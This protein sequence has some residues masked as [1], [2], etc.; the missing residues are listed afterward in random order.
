[1]TTSQGELTADSL[2]CILQ[3]H[4]TAIMS[5]IALQQARFSD[6]VDA[7][8]DA[9]VSERIA[10][11][12]MDEESF[13]ASMIKAVAASTQTAFATMSADLSERVTSTVKA[14]VSALDVKFRALLDSSSSV[15]SGS[16]ALSLSSQQSAR[17]T[18]DS[19]NSRQVWRCP[20]CQFPLKHEKSFH[21]HL[22]L[23]QSRVHEMPVVYG[24]RRS[25]KVKKCLFNIERPELHLLL[26]PWADSHPTFWSQAHEFVRHLLC[27]LKPGTEQAIQ[28]DNPRHEIVF[29]WIDNCRNG[30]FK[31]NP[32]F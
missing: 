8:I 20:V 6:E 15:H 7:K 26:Q 17:S 27:M 10:V 5:Q 30:V 21:D 25:Q 24:R 18:S 2:R 29:Q 3:E 28:D 23:L 14:E 4:Q 16:Q 9:K 22:V 11:F 32:F 12:K 31:P 1:M 19:R 13:K